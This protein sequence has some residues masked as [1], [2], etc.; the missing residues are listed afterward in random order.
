MRGRLARIPRPALAGLLVFAAS[1]GLYA[2]TTQPLTGYEPETA[3]AAEGLVLEGHLYEVEGGTPQLNSSAPG[4]NGHRY[5]RAGLPQA[6]LEAPFSA[7]GHLADDTFGHFSSFPNSYAFLWFYNPFVAALGALAIFALVFIT[8]R[9]LRWATAIAVL[10]V[11]ASI[12][13]P[14]SKIGMQTTFMAATIGAFAIGAWARRSPSALSWGLTGFATGT[15]MATKPYALIFFAPIA[16][17]LWPTWRSL[18]REGRFR[19]GIAV[20]APVLLWL[21]VIAWYNWY[22]FGAVTSFGYPES[23]LTLT[24]PLNFLGLLFSPG[25]GL[26]LYSPLVVLGAFG[27]P[28]LWR[29]DRALAAALATFFLGLT[30]VAASSTY[31]GDEVWGPRYL[32]PAAW[33]MLIPIAWWADSLTRRKAVAWLAAVA[34]GVQVIGVAAQ[35][36]HYLKVVRALTGVPLLRDR[37]GVPTERIPYGI[38]PMRWIPE[39]SPLVVQTEELLSTQVVERVTGEGLTISYP[40]FEGRSRTVDLSEPKLRTRLDFWWSA[41]PR[42]RGLA[43]LLA[44]LILAVSVAAWVAL[45]R[46]SFGRGFLRVGRFRL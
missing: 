10:F 8:R 43:T 38:D 26:I 41:A 7:A 23:T 40:P 19:L 6:L 25:K 32:V 33:T 22:R 2:V 37:E 9:S 18:D 36:S 12:A 13:W 24:A 11:F 3:T 42:Y 39:L 21:A 4:R 15:A 28:R 29:Q 34:I 45:Y 31:W 1:W 44:A 35:Y 27:M 5:A 46:L 17:L 20:C 30:A 14:Y 16:V